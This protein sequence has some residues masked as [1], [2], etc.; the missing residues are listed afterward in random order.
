[1]GLIGVL[2]VPFEEGDGGG[3]RDVEGAGWTGDWDVN[4]QVTLVQNYIADAV[5]LV[6][7]YESGISWKFGFVYVCG[8]RCRFDGDDFFICGNQ[9]AEVVFFCE[10]P[11]YVVAA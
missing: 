2:A 4:D 8:V 1:M 7:D 3:M 10:V 11:F 6:S 5:A 9:F